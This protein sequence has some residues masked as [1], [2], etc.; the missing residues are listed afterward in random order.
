MIESIAAIVI[1]V[2]AGYENDVV[3]RSYKRYVVSNRD[4]KFAYNLHQILGAKSSRPQL[5]S[6]S[7]PCLKMGAIPS[8]C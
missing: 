2:E 5:S 4:L 6:T 1:V 8:I 7:T 3:A